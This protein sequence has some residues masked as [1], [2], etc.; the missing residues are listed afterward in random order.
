[1]AYSVGKT[2]ALQTALKAGVDIALAELAA[3]IIAGDQVMVRV[4]EVADELKVELFAQADADNAV[5]ASS[6]APRSGGSNRVSSG[7]VS[8]ADA[9]GLVLNFGWAKGLTIGDVLV[10]DKADTAAYS[11][12]KYSRSG[13]DYITWMSTNKDPKGA[14]AAARAKVALDDYRSTTA[15][16]NTIAG[17]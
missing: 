12:G 4:H 17:P 13:F 15:G 9:K 1:M 7:P 16:L 11:N 8:V 10:M 14:F 6:P 5:I 3:G 2:S